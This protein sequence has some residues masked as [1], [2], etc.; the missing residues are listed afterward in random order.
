[1]SQIIQVD[2]NNFEVQVLGSKKPILVDFFADWCGPC[3]NM[4]P[5]LEALAEYWKGEIL[6]AKVDTD[7]PINAQ[8]V[9]FYQ[10]RGIPNLKLFK[11]GQLVKEFVGFRS[12]EELRSEVEAIV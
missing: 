8:L 7:N 3:K 4:E 6:V 2:A 12:E 9:T 11:A 10:I 1:M 5:V